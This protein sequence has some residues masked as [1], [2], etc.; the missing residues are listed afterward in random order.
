MTAHS[1]RGQG[2]PPLYEGVV[3]PA[4]GDPWTPEQQRQ[5][6]RSHTQPSAGQPWGQPW[7]PESQ[8]AQ[9]WGPESQAVMTP[10]DQPGASLPPPPQSPPPPPPQQPPYIPPQQH[11]PGTNPEEAVPGAGGRHGGGQQP[12]PPGFPPADL[13][14]ASVPPPQ[15]AGADLPPAQPQQQGPQA[16]QASFLPEPHNAQAF[17][18]GAQLPPQQAPQPQPQQPP[19]DQEFAQ[20]PGPLQAFPQQGVSSAMPP[21][22]P[23]AAATTADSDAT[24]FLPPVVGDPGTSPPG[25][26]QAAQPPPAMDADAT[27]MLPPQTGQ[28]SARD[29]ES[30]ARLRTPL[31]PEAPAAGQG[32]GGGAGGRQQP[33]AGFENL[34][35]SES[36]SDQGGSGNPGDPGA[37]QRLPLFDQAA[38]RQR[39]G[40]GAGRFGKPDGPGGPAAA[41]GQGQGAG[42][43]AGQSGQWEPQGRAARRNAERSTLSRMS[44]AL[45]IAVGVAVVA[46]VGMAAGAALSGG[47]DEDGKQKSQ[48]SPAQAD[49][50][51]AGPDPV[52]AQAKE[53]DKLLADS[54][55]SR[56]SVIRSVENIKKCKKLGQA[57]GDLRAAA[58][59]RN[60]LVTRLGKLETDKIPANAELRSALVRAW[61]ASASADSHYAAWADEAARKKGC[62]KGKA[63][64]TAHTGQGAR[65]SGEATAAKKKAAGLWN[66]TAKKY[67]L[68]ERQVV[69]L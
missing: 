54:N 59:Q 17:G 64:A 35:R 56:A 20:G 32:T 51:S 26:Y 57:A 2:D 6:D 42:R 8:D 61:K 34:F 15:P 18:G 49:E 46:G 7:G 21:A 36:V 5:V 9:P 4:N 67:G 48:S 19:A 45:L 58:D 65:A 38:A 53:L 55:N 60:G 41:Y 10:G 43:D 30:T 50:K 47:G 40:A 29:P 52:E 31:P 39:N 33:P 68:K 63:R 62:R 23:P 37:T 1:G 44:P 3:L 11:P 22:A 27:Q 24:Q 16:P 66:P 14:P 25:G 69:Q 12:P 13:P 28:A